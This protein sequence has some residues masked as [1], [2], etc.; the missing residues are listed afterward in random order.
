MNTE[1]SGITL[2]ERFACWKIS[3]LVYFTKMLLLT[4]NEGVC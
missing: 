3:Y 4:L 2:I 1:N